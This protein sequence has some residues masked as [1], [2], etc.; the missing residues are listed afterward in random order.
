MEVQRPVDNTTRTL[1]LI[2]STD[3]LKG[4]KIVRNFAYLVYLLL[5]VCS[6]TTSGVLKTRKSKLVRLRT[7]GLKEILIGFQC[8][9]MI[10]G[11]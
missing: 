1:E 7:I 6:H 5:H 8:I 10:D 9:E 2:K 11:S 4:N 3:V